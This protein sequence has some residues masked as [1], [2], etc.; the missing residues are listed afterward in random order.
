MA[1]LCMAGESEWRTGSPTMA[2]TR[3]VA[4]TGITELAH[5][6]FDGRSNQGLQ[7]IVRLAIQFQVSAERVAHLGLR[8][9]AAGVLTQYVG[10]PL[11]SKL[12]HPSP[13]MPG[14]GEDDVRL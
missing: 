3:L 5:Q 8:P 7:L 14:H 12:M 4:P 10:P 6:P 9:G 1:A 11:A 13:V 2:S